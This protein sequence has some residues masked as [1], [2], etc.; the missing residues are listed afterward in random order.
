MFYLFFTLFY[1]TLVGYG[2]TALKVLVRSKG[3]M[4]AYWLII[5]G[6][7]IAG[8]V[9]RVAEVPLS[10]RV[11]L[12]LTGSLFAVTFGLLLLSFFLILEDLARFFTWLNALVKRLAGRPHNTRI[13]RRR[14]ISATAVTVGALPFSSLLIGMGARNKYTLHSYDL[15]F[16]RLPAAFDG[17]TVIQISDL[18]L[19]S[20]ASLEEF[21]PGLDLINEQQA[22]L[23]LFTGDMVNDH[24]AEAL[25]Y[26]EALAG[27][28]ANDGKYAVLGNH[29]YG[30]YNRAFDEQMAKEDVLK[31]L[32][33]QRN[34]G[35][36]TLN[37]ESVKVYRNG[38]YFNLVG[39]ENW[40]TGRFLKAGDL[41]KA[42]D[43]IDDEVFTLLMSHDPSHWEAEVI[44]HQKRIDLCLS[45]HTH[46][47]QFG[48]EIAGYQWSPIQYRYPQWAGMYE[49]N[50]RLLNVNRGFG[51]LGY[52]G[53]FG[54]WPEITRIR[55][56]SGK[57]ASVQ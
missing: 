33:I 3:W 20:F 10:A 30:T 16:D 49:K 57:F 37:N 12:Y 43:Q 18:H 39:V 21:Q 11:S 54:I 52:P 6:L 32:E 23:L 36:T 25:P 34:M 13:D 19:G 31:L 51:F 26:V 44:E 28:R 27:L 29:D 15:V 55:L 2:Y 40:G 14:F 47:F 42:T 8:F 22:D 41:Q 53:R 7:F 38:A 56:K 48:V 17:Y 35:F 9:L 45:G 50:D 5:V 4:W 1:L 46:G 24:S